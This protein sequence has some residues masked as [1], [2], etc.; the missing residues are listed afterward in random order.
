[1]SSDVQF[2]IVEGND[3]VDTIDV[4]EFKKDFLDPS[5]SVN[6]ICEKHNISKNNYQRLKKEHFPD[7]RKPFIVNTAPICDIDRY[8]SQRDGGYVV[9]KRISGS[10]RYFGI[11]NTLEQAR[12]VRDILESNNWDVGLYYELKEHSAKSYPLKNHCREIYDEFR[13]DYM[14]GIPYKTLIKKYGITTHQYSVLS[15][16]IREELG[17]KRKPTVGVVKL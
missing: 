4:E 1:M 5:L 6:D 12:T 7:T 14:G 3:C 15:K 11:W 8:I 13:R 17:I 9:S 16:W 10:Q 2:R